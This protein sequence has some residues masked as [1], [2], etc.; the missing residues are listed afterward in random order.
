MKQRLKSFCYLNF[1]LL[2]A[3]SHSYLASQEVMAYPGVI[4]TEVGA[5]DSG[6]SGDSG[7][8]MPDVK[9]MQIKSIYAGHDGGSFF[10]ASENGNYRL[11]VNGLFQFRFVSTSRG[12]ESGRP[13]ISPDDDHESGFEFRRVELAF[14]GNVVTPRLKYKLVIA[15]E[16]GALGVEQII[17]QD[18]LISYEVNDH[19]TI[20][21]GRYFAPLLREELIGGGGSLPL[22]LSYMNNELSIGRGEGVSVLYNHE[23]VRGHIFIHDGAGSGGGGGINNPAGDTT[24]IALTARGDVRLQGDWGQWGDFT[25]DGAPAVFVGVAFH[26]ETGEVGDAVVAN[27][28]N[29]Y[30]WTVDASVET[31][32][33]HIY[34]AVAGEHFDNKTVPDVNNYGILA[35]VG[36]RIPGTRLEPFAR[37]ELVM[38]DSSLGYVED[39][40][41]LITFGTNFHV[42]EALEVGAD[43]V[44]ALDPI[45]TDSLNAGLLADGAKDNQIV[46]RI[47]AQLKV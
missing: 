46:F 27:D 11:N 14:H 34:F 22:A 44:W 28:Y 17:A 37:G 6:A 32:G 24:T 9:N 16:D 38:F 40:V 35:Q 42:N 3:A 25:N 18:V 1:T 45:P 7:V 5:A 10:V 47:Q 4:Q 23:V 36:Y 12:S 20:S 26:V 19:F 31:S 33:F 39:N 15:T 21:G 29:L 30:N 43:V 13:S 2:V 41:T 8:A